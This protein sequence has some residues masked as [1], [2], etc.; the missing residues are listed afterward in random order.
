MSNQYVKAYNANMAA[1]NNQP[2][3]LPEEDPLAILSEE[4]IANFNNFQQPQ[5]QADPLTI[6]S[7]TDLSTDQAELYNSYTNASTL[8]GARYT[9]DELER[10]PKFQETASRFME[11]IGR[12]EE[13]F[14][15]LRDSDWSLA[16]ALMRS[17]EIKTGQVKPN[18]IIYTYVRCLITQIL[19]VSN[20]Q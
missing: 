4:Q 2:A 20:K 13:I 17:R 1:M 6:E 11:E 8:T 19:V 10:D 3:F 9:L 15:Y 18:K 5:P 14:E 12:D 7:E 16:S